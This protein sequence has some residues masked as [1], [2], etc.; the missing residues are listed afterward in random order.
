MTYID[1][2]YESFLFAL[3]NILNLTLKSFNIQE[4]RNKELKNIYVK[5]C[6]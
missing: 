3:G 4:R 5:I 2:Q 6:M 1:C